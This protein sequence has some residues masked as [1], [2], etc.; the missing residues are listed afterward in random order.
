M[1]TNFETQDNKELPEL[2]PIA[3]KNIISGQRAYCYE[4]SIPKA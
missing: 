2:H 4:L 1:Q 3:A